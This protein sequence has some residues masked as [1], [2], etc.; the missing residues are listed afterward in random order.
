MTTKNPPNPYDPNSIHA[1]MGRSMALHQGGQVAEAERLYKSALA[2]NPD[3]F[4]ALHFFGLL[5]AQRGH[6]VEADEFMRRSL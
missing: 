2:L 3:H 5:E 6:N 1:I 4:E